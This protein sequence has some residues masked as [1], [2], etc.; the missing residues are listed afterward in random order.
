MAT[1]QANKTFT[2]GLAF[3]ANPVNANFKSLKDFANNSVV[4]LDGTKSFSGDL[5]MGGYKV[6]DLGTPTVDGD[7]AT[8]GYADDRI[9]LPQSAWTFSGETMVLQSYP[10]HYA[11]L[12]SNP[13]Q[14]ATGLDGSVSFTAGV[15]PVNTPAN[16]PTLTF[17]APGNYLVDIRAEKSGG[18]GDGFWNDGT[19]QFTGWIAGWTA[20][21]DF[22]YTGAYRRTG[23]SN[24]W[25]SADFKGR[26]IGV[27]QIRTTGS[28][29]FWSGHSVPGT[30]SDYRA[31]GHV[32][33]YKLGDF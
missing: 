23:F 13:T 25:A 10:A 4:H 12:M 21:Y 17:S 31:G 9:V 14:I 24:D 6:T 32:R 8:K 15:N 26:L 27:L 1:V 3:D 2:D 20:T 19:S 29:Y 22:N 16:Y 30:Y 5:A 33:V 7:I 18:T 11:F 28:M